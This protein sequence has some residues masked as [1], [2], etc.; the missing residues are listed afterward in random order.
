MC[1]VVKRNVKVP[2]PLVHFCS[3]IVMQ[4]NIHRREVEDMLKEV[5]KVEHENLQAMSELFECHVDD[6][7]I[8]RCVSDHVSA[9]YV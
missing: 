1:Q 6:L 7:K 2:A 5:E 9:V 3:F 8:S 4:V